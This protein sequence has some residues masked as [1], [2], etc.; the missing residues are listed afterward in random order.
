MLRR[1]FLFTSGILFPAMLAA[2][3]ALLATPAKSVISALIVQ[4]QLKGNFDHMEPLKKALSGQIR[5]I[6]CGEIKD[7]VY[8]GTGFAV[9]TADNKIILTKKILFNTFYKIDGPRNTIEIKTVNAVFHLN[10][11]AQQD[12]DR[13]AFWSF[14]SGTFP[15]E[16]YKP[17]LNRKGSAFMCIS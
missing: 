3:A 15:A 13:P 14:R 10:Y 4:G 7:L 17:F 11:N 2:P 5:E 1:N 12:A 16:K 8:T 9:T 6:G